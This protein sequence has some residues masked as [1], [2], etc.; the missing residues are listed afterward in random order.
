MGDPQ[1]HEIGG[2][3]DAR[4]RLSSPWY[5]WYIF[6]VCG[7]MY[8]LSHFWR[9][10][11]A[12]I[13]GDLSRDLGLSTEMLGLVGGAFFYSFGLL[14]LPMGPLLDR[15]GPRLVISLLGM[16][17]AASAAL[18]ALSESGAVMVL[19]RAGI[20]IGMAAALMGS[21]KMFTTW[22]SPREFATLS[23]IMLAIGNT[24]A[25][26]ATTP[27]AWLSEVFGWRLAC[28]GMA[29]VTMLMAGAVYLVARDHPP[30][31]SGMPPHTVSSIAAVWQGI[32]TVFCTGAFWRIVPLGFATNGA[33]IT[34]QGLW[35]GPYLVH[36]YGM[37]KAAAGSVLLA[38]PVGL[39][40]GAPLWGRL[41]DVLMRRKRIIL[42]G[43]IIMLLASASLALH[44][45][46]PRWG[47][48]L[49]FWLIGFTASSAY[50]LYAQVKET[51]PLAIAATALT[52]L[53]FFNILG[54]AMF[55][56]IT[57]I[58]MG[59][60]QPSAGGALPVLFLALAVYV[61]STDSIPAVH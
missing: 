56:Q 11:N 60:W 12:V 27:F 50:V 47:L 19:A 61:T 38:I 4:E 9:V 59:N 35:G 31:Q 26:G 28:G 54:A 51:F 13:A 1:M 5:R 29:L 2:G 21:Y 49:Q 25:V 52:S 16:V 20:G 37:S 30:R 14:Q 7:G 22:F 42:T 57:G 33:L 44:L 48:L 17:G 6:A 18:F 53:N 40:C 32:K 24:G 45:P 23:G 41:S 39:V 10:S 36:C 46:L 15:F 8:V 58:I 55:Q 43:Q 34:A 3:G